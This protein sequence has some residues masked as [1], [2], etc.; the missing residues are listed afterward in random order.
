MLKIGLTG[1]IGSGKSMVAHV[2]ELLGIPVYS[3]DAA[4][5]KL[6]NEDEHRTSD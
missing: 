5:K 6:M 3:A 1:G 4:A 2:F